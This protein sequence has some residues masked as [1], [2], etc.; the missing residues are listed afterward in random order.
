MSLPFTAL[1]YAI[2]PQSEKNGRY[3]AKEPEACPVVMPKLFISVMSGRSSI[4]FKIN[5][6][7]DGLS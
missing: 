1:K 5:R 4:F 6:Y 7:V 2:T 3:D